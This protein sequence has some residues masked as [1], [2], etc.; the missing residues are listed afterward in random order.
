[1]W[2]VAFLNQAR[3]DWKT[4]KEIQELTTLD[5]C[6]KLYYL[7]VATEK[8]GK[9]ALLHGNGY[10]PD[11]IRKHKLF[12]KYLQQAHK[13]PRLCKVLGKKPSQVKEYIDSILSIATSIEN[14]APGEGNFGK[15]AEYPWE[16]SGIV[17]SPCSYNFPE[18]PEL[19]AVHG[20][21]YINLVKLL[22]EK[23]E[24]IYK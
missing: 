5:G 10:T 24:A 8:L 21:K 9:A 4:Y 14:L 7:R 23:F 11:N 1:M 18:L 20:K 12:V 19:E 15:N 13:N 17:Y 6:H 3:S 2:G 16:L 22:L